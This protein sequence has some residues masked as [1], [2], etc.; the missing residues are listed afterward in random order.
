VGNVSRVADGASWVKPTWLYGE[1]S[2]RTE[3]LRQGLKECSCIYCL[4]IVF[5][6]AAAALETV[7]LLLINK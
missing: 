3:A 2:G 5:L 6:F 7:T 4:I 1:V